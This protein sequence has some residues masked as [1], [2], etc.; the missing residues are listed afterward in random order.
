MHFPELKKQTTYSWSYFIS[1]TQILS[2]SDSS[3]QKSVL[4]L[5]C[6][7]LFIPVPRL[8]HGNPRDQS[9]TGQIADRLSAAC[10]GNLSRGVD[11]AID[12]SGTGRCEPVDSR[13]HDTSSPT[14]SRCCHNVCGR[15]VG[16]V[17]VDLWNHKR[18]EQPFAKLGFWKCSNFTE[19]IS[20][21][22][23]KWDFIVLVSRI[24]SKTFFFFFFK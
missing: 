20:E 13:S 12:Y 2:P 14:P 15:L 11:D 19:K 10:W 9:R 4:T 18:I 17:V 7:T 3:H 24:S 1:R 23:M 5:F 22:L 21:N 8:H 16:R 6:C